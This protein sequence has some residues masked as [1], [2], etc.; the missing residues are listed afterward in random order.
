[1]VKPPLTRILLKAYG[2]LNYRLSG[3]D[4]L[5]SARFD[6]AARLP[7]RRYRGEQLAAMLQNLLAGG[8]KLTLHHETK[9]MAGI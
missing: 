5:D 4:W 8:F 1:M 2:I 7:P 3:P 6:I 9:E